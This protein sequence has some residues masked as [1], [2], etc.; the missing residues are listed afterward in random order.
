M[1]EKCGHNGGQG[2]GAGHTCVCTGTK[3]HAPFNGVGHGCSCGALWRDSVIPE[4]HIGQSEPMMV[5]NLRYVLDEKGVKLTADILELAVSSTVRFLLS[6]G[7]LARVS[8]STGLSLQTVT[9][10]ARELRQA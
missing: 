5:T 6:P 8:A 2:I 9:E 7:Q 1:A 10:I 4:P 3:G